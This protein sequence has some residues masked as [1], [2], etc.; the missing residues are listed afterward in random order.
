MV[1]WGYGLETPGESEPHLHMLVNRSKSVYYCLEF[2][3]GNPLSYGL[4]REAGH[5]SGYFVSAF[6]KYWYVD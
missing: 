5:C 4:R 3:S 2:R 6:E 1:L